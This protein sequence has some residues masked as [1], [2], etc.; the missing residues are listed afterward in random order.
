MV[1]TWMPPWIVCDD[2]RVGVFRVFEV[3][4]YP[5]FLHHARCKIEIRF[6]ILH[7]EV[8]RLVLSP[9]FHFEVKSFQYFHQNIRHALTLEDA[10]LTRLREHPQLR[11]DLQLVGCKLRV[12][13]ALGKSVNYSVEVPRGP[14]ALDQFYHYGFPK[15]VCRLDHM[16]RSCFGIFLMQK[17]DR[18]TEQARNAFAPGERLNKKEI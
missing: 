15:D 12:P 13:A 3:V 4:E 18:K 14:A 9:E 16:R 5:L 6:P 7:T 17:V 11:Y 8:S 10:T 1:R 2:H